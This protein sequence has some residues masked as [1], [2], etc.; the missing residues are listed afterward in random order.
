MPRGPQINS[1]SGPIKA[2]AGPDYH[3]NLFLHIVRHAY[4][5][6]SRDFADFLCSQSGH[7]LKICLCVVCCLCQIMAHHTPWEQNG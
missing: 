5:E 6:V 3:H 1:A 2:W 7:W 4:S